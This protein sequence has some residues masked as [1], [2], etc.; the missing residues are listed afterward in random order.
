MSNFL[1]AA[2]HGGRAGETVMGVSYSSSDA[3]RDEKSRESGEL[4]K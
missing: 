1:S 2:W 4:R 3:A